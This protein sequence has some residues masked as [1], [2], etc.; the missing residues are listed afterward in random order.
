MRISDWSSDVCSSDLLA[1]GRCPRPR[2]AAR[3]AAR[4][5]PGRHHRKL[6][7]GLPVS[8]PA[9]RPLVAVDWGISSFRAYL[10]DAEGHISERH[11]STGGILRVRGGAF[12]TALDAE[13]GPWLSSR[14]A[15]LAVMSGMI[16]QI[17][18]EWVRDKVGVD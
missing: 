6:H 17:G 16:G 12:A 11:E 2:A 10:L 3:P 7:R 9:A 18:R 5:Q 14:P 15:A 4:S 1:E 13:I 8:G